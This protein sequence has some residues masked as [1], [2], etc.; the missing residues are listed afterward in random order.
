MAANTRPGGGAGAIAALAVVIGLLLAGAY[1]LWTQDLRR[2]AQFPPYSVQRTDAEG[3]AVVYR[4]Y[5][6]TGLQPEIWDQDLTR[7]KAPGLLVMIAPTPKIKLRGELEIGQQGDLLPHEIEALDQWVKA[8]N[9]LVVMSREPNDLFVSLGLIADEPKGSSAAV[10]EPTQP[11][12]LA[13]GVEKVQTQT[14]FGFKYGRQPD[15]MSKALGV[16]AVEPPISAIPAGEWV[17]LFVKKN[18]DRSVSQVV[19]AARGKGL[20]VAVNDAFPAG[21][22]GIATADNAEFMMNIARLT[23]AG[24]KLW[25]DEYHKRAVERGFVTYLRERAMLPVLIYV[26]LLVGLL[27]WRSSVRFGEVQPLVVDRR[28]DSGEYVKAV[29]TL[30]QGA[31]MPRE[32]LSTIFADFRRR[33]VGALRLDGRA[34]LDEV[35]RRYE[36][37]TGRPAIEA[38]GA[39]IET[40]AALAREKLDEAE[41]LQFCAR[42]TQLDEALHR[43][44]EGRA[45][46]RK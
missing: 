40:E 17:E 41:A 4:L 3:A 31:G 46:P 29:A 14:E 42:L 32:A 2:G 35:G 24:G 26:L 43:R 33:L 39:L 8:G 34:N 45:S 19:S 21:N 27:F 9:V 15:E 37:R 6:Q 23:P 44:E 18:G 38:R 30:Y 12:V 7:L 36:Q 28:R 1:F 25:I 16:K 5:Q 10:A 11:S 20:Y 13:R 22:L